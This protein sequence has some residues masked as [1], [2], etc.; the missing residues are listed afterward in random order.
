[1]AFTGPYG[2]ATEPATG[3]IIYAGYDQEGLERQ[4]NLRLSHPERESVY[5][6]YTAASELLRSQ[7]P[8]PF[9]QPYGESPWETLDIFPAGDGA[10]VLIFFH[11][12]YWRALDKETFSFMAKPFTEA[13]YA[14]VMAN[15]QLCPAVT[16]DRVVAESRAAVAWVARN[17]AS[18]GG[19][20]TRIAVSGHSAG[21]HLTLMCILHDWRG[22]GFD[23]QLVRCGVPISGLFDLE[24]LR[25]TS[26]NDLV[27]MDQEMALRNS[28]SRLAGPCPVPLLIMAGGAETEQFR[29]QSTGFAKTWHSHGNPCTVALPPGLNHFT[30]L[31]PLGEAQTPLFRQVRDFLAAHLA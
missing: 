6:T 19:D 8:G 31:G 25:H 4:Y 26:V 7:T 3:E 22:A 15:Y 24:P 30:V 12:G 16:L 17:A 18:F 29:S 20:P 11:G 21:G 27:Q 10:P 1:M 9:D 5:A 28:P 14:V 23:R 2:A 13:G